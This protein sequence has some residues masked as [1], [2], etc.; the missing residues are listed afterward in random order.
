VYTVTVTGANGCSGDDAVQVIEDV[1]AP[2]AQATA[3]RPLTCENPETTLSAGVTG[4]RPPYVVEW[5]GP[6]GNVIGKTM[7]VPVARPGT[8]TVS[9]TGANGCLASAAVTVIRDIEPPLVSVT[10]DRALTCAEPEVTLTAAVTGGRPPYTI[11]WQN[12]CGTQLGSTES[13]LVREA[14]A[15]FVVVTG[16][17][18][19]SVSGSVV[20]VEDVET[21]T[22]TATGGRSLTCAAS[23]TTLTADV[24]GGRPPYVVEWRT[25]RGMLLAYGRSITVSE[26]GTYVVTAVG[27]NGCRATDSVTVTEDVAPPL[28]DAGPDRALTCDNTLALLDI[29]V[30]GGI[31]P[32]AY[33]W[34]DDCGKV[35]ATTEDITVT[36]PGLYT[37]VVA[38]ANGCA[39]SASVRVASKIAPPTV[40]AGPDRLLTCD[41]DEVL[42]DATV[43]GGSAPY[44]YAWTDAC[45]VVVGTAEDLWVTQSGV[46]TLLVR[47]ADG[48]VGMDSVIITQASD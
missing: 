21:P 4:G 43:R 8:Y 45:G 28:V 41:T 7:K 1:E 40:D 2:V 32:Y 16:A 30:H 18:G 5:R 26:P 39:S 6:D 20:V 17:N 25:D 42:L 29:T 47:T 15:Y 9:V 14:G 3:E 27:A 24:A 10:A 46:Y 13:I 23:Q 22:V 33:R 19:C 34:T 48:C 38:G 37:V 12:A 44:Q 31:A 36:R 35:I 11:E